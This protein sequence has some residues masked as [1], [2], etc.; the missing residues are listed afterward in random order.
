MSTTTTA[1]LPAPAAP[2]PG[3]TASVRTAAAGRPGPGAGEPAAPG[4]AGAGPVGS[5]GPNAGAP[6]AAPCPA[7]A[8]HAGPAAA[9]SAGGGLAG[10]G[11]VDAGPGAHARA[12]VTGM[13]A[14]Q[15][16]ESRAVA[17]RLR[18]VARL[19]GAVRE[20][21]VAEAHEALAACGE[22]SGAG[23]A[24]RVDGC[25]LPGNGKQS[26]P[27]AATRLSSP[28]GDLPA[29]AGT[30]SAGPRQHGR[31][32]LPSASAPHR[33]RCAAPGAARTARRV[34]DEL[35]AGLTR[36]RL[37]L[38]TAAEVGVALRLP[39]GTA[40]TVVAEA[41]VLIEDLP[42]V[43]TALEA[44]TIT[45]PHARVAVQ[46]WQELVDEAPRD[47]L[48]VDRAVVLVQEMLERAPHVTVA[49]LRAF[50]HRRRARL[51]ADAEER[52]RRAARK[53]RTVWVEPAEDGLAWVHALLDAPVARAV[54]DRVERLAGTVLAAERQRVPDGLQARPGTGPEDRE[55][56][57]AGEVRADVLADLLLDGELPERSGVPRG[58]RGRVCV[59]VPVGILLAPDAAAG[60]TSSPASGA[61]AELEGYGPI[62]AEVARRLAAGAGSWHRLLTHPVSG[63][64]LEHDRSVYA[65]PADLRRHLRV[66]DDTCRFPGCRRP[67]GG[68]D[69]DHT[70]AWEDGGTTGASNLAH[71]CRHHHLVEHRGGPLG[72]WSVRRVPGPGGARDPG[73]LEWRS[74]SGVV[75]RTVPETAGPEASRVLDPGGPPGGRPGG[76]RAGH[77]TDSAL[78]GTAAGASHRTGADDHPP[79]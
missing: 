53:H 49:Q 23:G 21:R 22:A 59:T 48:P 52:R 65:V 76:G 27:R 38:E 62:G 70:V 56:R 69:V 58:I 41:L 72:Q 45:W 67:A 40:A 10:A 68:A 19:F 39:A 77:G 37:V 78:P 57:S 13:L 11:D 46:Q 16:A 30:S 61:A 28:A 15:A 43:L 32:G 64:V 66:R 35:L 74:P 50:A 18:C 26:S 5:T 47:A 17:V 71:L 25:G 3:A 9:G 6:G 7:G 4:S 14:A 60:W 20:A 24:R 54:E 1:P 8:A 51:L 55:Q 29:A 44:G 34:H 79:F 63:V 73:V 42:D 2:S 36:H 31:H 12:A 33:H 75:R